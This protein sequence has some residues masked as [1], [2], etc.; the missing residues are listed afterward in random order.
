MQVFLII[1][2]NIF[3]FFC[4]CTSCKLDENIISEN[5]ESKIGKQVNWGTPL[6]SVEEYLNQVLE[7]PLSADHAV[8]IALFF[9]PE[10]QAIFED[11]GIAYAD[12]IQAG[13]FR[14]PFFDIAVRFPNKGGFVTDVEY[15]VVGYFLDIFLVP[16]RK[17][18][19]KAE[20]EKVQL[21]VTHSILD[22]AFEVERI[23]YLLVAEQKR[24]LI[25]KNITEILEGS[26]EIAL[27]QYEAG[28]IY[29]ADVEKKYNEELSATMEK[30]QSELLV[31]Q[32][33]NALNRLMGFENSPIEWEV[34]TLLLQPNLEEPTLDALQERVLKERFDLLALQWEY[35]K[36]ARTGALKKWWAYTDV[37][38]GI[39]GE[40]EPEGVVITGPAIGGQIPIFDYGQA[41]R[42]RLSALLRQ[43]RDRYWS[44]RIF[45]RNEVDSTYKSLQTLREMLCTYQEEILPNVK[46]KMAVS[47][48]L[49]NAM[50]LSPYDLIEAK[51][52]Q[53][54]EEIN[55][56]VV[57]R[58]YWIHFVQ[59][60]KAI[61]GKI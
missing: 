43:S 44:L 36:I 31:I 10:I 8:Q 35:E 11:L 50:T 46:R 29:L 55:Y 27:A 7:K 13:L 48:K 34:P 9:N 58:D 60:K 26:Y 2:V 18:V 47:Q 16:L 56:I 61:G 5:I 37:I 45:I 41:D 30:N 51:R 40:R 3:L 1:L 52:Q 24:Y 33:K 23:Y 25:L 57:L 53:Y 38:L 49:Y 32:W 28:N 21:K 19:A 14:N 4:G 6:S 17:K 59:L 54:M 42:A 20:F 39:A 22:L 12:L 15:S